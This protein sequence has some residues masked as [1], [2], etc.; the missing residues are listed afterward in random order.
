MIQHN[1]LRRENCLD[2]VAFLNE[3]ESSADFLHVALRILIDIFVGISMSASVF[4]IGG[5][6]YSSAS[7]GSSRVRSIEEVSRSSE[8]SYYDRDLSVISGFTQRI[9]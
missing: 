9:Y 5:M 2:P 3:A 7:E 4:E 6:Q 8:E 1:A